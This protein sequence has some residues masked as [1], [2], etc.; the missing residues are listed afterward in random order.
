MSH[1]YVTYAPPREGGVTAKVVRTV[2]ITH[3]VSHCLHSDILKLDIY[4]Y[5]WNG[6]LTVTTAAFL[7]IWC[8][9]NPE[10][11]ANLSRHPRHVKTYFAP[12]LLSIPSCTGPCF[13]VIY[14]LLSWLW[15]LDCNEAGAAHSQLQ[16]GNWVGWG[17]IHYHTLCAGVWG[18][19]TFVANHDRSHH[20]VPL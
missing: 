18:V 3:T 8:E 4:Y 6:V 5:A 2:Q 15:G 10:V 17:R 11:K 16:R 19:V 14:V 12:F 9:I 7:L 20:A 1:V 13:H